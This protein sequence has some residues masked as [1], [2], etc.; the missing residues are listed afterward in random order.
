VDAHHSLDTAWVWT[1]LDRT[2]LVVW[3]W[4][5]HCW[6]SGFPQ[7]VHSET[8]GSVKGVRSGLGRAR[9][10]LACHHS[11]GG[12][13]CSPIYFML[14]SFSPHSLVS[15]VV[16]LPFV[17]SPFFSSHMSHLDFSSTPICPPV[18]PPFFSFFLRPICVLHIRTQGKG[19]SQSGGVVIWNS[20]LGESGSFWKWQKRLATLLLSRPLRCVYMCARVCVP[21][22]CLG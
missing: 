21:C 1:G 4:M 20:R 12:G 2:G 18:S 10:C 5:R 9:R 15:H 6:K 16:A 8:G 11:E 3:C 7:A 19:G 22:A 14:F 17:L 13:A